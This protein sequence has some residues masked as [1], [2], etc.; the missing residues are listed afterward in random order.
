MIRFISVT[1]E[2]MLNLEWGQPGLATDCPEFIGWLQLIGGIKGAE[3][4]FE[5]IP[6]T[7]IDRR[8]ACWAEIPA[9]ILM[10]L[11]LNLH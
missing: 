2:E 11:A 4:D 6:G 10:C 1:A 3:V 7:R 5:F 8:A 9:T